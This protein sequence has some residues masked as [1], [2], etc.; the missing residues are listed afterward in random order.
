MRR[1]GGNG[2]DA[3]SLPAYAVTRKV[4]RSDATLTGTEV[5][6]VSGSAWAQVVSYCP[7][8]P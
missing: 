1:S 5:T 6:D 8:S 2:V 4:K 3:R 7:T